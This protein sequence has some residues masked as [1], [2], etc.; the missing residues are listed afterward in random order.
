MTGGKTPAEIRR[1]NRKAFDLFWS[2]YPR[3]V[4]PTEAE[5]VFSDIVQSGQDPEYLIQKARYYA[6]TVDPN[7]LRYVPAPHAWL[8]QGRYDDEDLFTNQASQ[9]REWFRQC[10][11]DCNVKAIENRYHVTFEKQYPPDGM[12]DADAIKLWYRETARA[13]ISKTYEEMI[14]CRDMKQPTT[15][16]QSSPLS[17]PCSSTPES[18]LT[19][20][21]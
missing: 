19:S 8:R 7:D 12:Q 6:A 10:W 3:K 17:E 1:K 13:W 2:A 14:A 20:T 18:S 4:A 5:R 16:S 11:K 15:S 9:E 21:G